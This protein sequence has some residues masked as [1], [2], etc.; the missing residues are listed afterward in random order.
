MVYMLSG[1]ELAEAKQISDDHAGR[2][3]RRTTCAFRPA[4]Y[5]TVET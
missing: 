5:A 2:A 3:I 4:M 1:V